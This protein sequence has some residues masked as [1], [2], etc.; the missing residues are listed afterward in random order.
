MGMR[1]REIAER[2]GG[3]VRGDG[4]CTI[5]RV[6]ALTEDQAGTI[7]FFAH[8]AYRHELRT[9][10]IS[11]VIL[12]R[13]DLAACP[14]N[15]LI[16]ANPYLTFARVA[17]L[18]HPAEPIEAGV[19]DSAIVEA[20]ARV[21]GS[22]HV[23]AQVVIEAG[24]RI[25]AHVYLGPGCIV[26][27]D[28][29]IGASARLV[30]AVTVCRG[31]R[32]GR[33]VLIHPGVVIGS[34]G[35]GFA[36]NGRLWEKIPQL[37]SVCIGDDVEIGA[38][39]TI[40]RGTLADTRI[41]RG[42]KIDNLVQIGHNAQIGEHTVIAGCVAIAGSVRVGR[43]CAL[44]GAVR[45]SD[46]VTIIDNVKVTCRSAVTRSI[47]EAGIYSGG[48]PLQTNRRWHRSAARFKQLD[49]MARRIAR[50]EQQLAT[51]RARDDAT[52]RSRR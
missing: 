12:R 16:C 19:H 8:P 1:L 10:T 2:S 38:N 28:A 15:A 11:A 9:T 25:E 34:E 40:D 4:D 51:Q 13:K 35:F 14:T 37:G 6:G 43:R 29:R 27:R 39:T 22:A 41:G 52:D 31:C 47:L 5:E 46:H 50:L 7:G 33:R 21:A 26:A 48:T 17:R 32:V 24:A 49:E 20:G 3:E 45:V 18:L 42:V 44:G 30:A 23:G 36:D